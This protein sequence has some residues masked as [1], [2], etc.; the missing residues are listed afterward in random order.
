MSY[1]NFKNEGENSQ[2]F[3]LDSTLAFT[4]YIVR[5]AQHPIAAEQFGVDRPGETEEH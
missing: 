5:L 2:N 3:P 4:L 1:S